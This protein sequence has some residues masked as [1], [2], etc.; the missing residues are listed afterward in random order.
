MRSTEPINASN[1]LQK[2]EKRDLMHIAYMYITTGI[3]DACTCAISMLA[4]RCCICCML[5][6]TWLKVVITGDLHEVCLAFQGPSCTMHSSEWEGS[7][8]VQHGMH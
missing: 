1:L 8:E 2:T 3:H 4:V 6:F 7:H 5:A